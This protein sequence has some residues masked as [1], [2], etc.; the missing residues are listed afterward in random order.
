MWRGEV[1]DRITA[2]HKLQNVFVC[3]AKCI[4]QDCKMYF[5]DGDGQRPCKVRR[6][7]VG[8]RKTA[9]LKLEIVFFQ[10]AN[11]ICPDHKI[12]FL[13]GDGQRP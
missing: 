2:E 4:C 6:A 5:L 9:E 12:Y 1:G 13:G 10:N 11:G 7:K 8:G 3:I